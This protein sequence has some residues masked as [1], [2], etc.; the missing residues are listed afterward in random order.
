M[1]TLYIPTP[2]PFHANC[3]NHYLALH[4]PPS[5]PTRRDQNNPTRLFGQIPTN[6]IIS[7]SP[8]PIS[9]TANTDEYARSAR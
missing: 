5:S 1:E 8:P 2:S 9:T 3:I 4:P 6:T 7:P